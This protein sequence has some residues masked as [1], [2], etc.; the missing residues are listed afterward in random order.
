[1]DP[2]DL[3]SDTVTRPS[4]GMR[5]AMAS[6]EVGDDVFGD[7]PTVNRLQETVAQLLG[8]ERAL[9]VASG[10]MGN[11]VAVR[12]L[13]EPGQEILMHR[14]SHV[15]LY[16][17]G[18]YAA[19]SGC[20]V[21]LLDGER[22][23]ID[24][25]A[26][27]AAI[28]PAD[29]HHPRSSL[30][31][32]ENTHNRGGGTVWPVARMAEI[33]ALADTRG[34][35][36]HLDGARLMNAC[37]ASG[38]PATAYTRHADTV[39]ICFSKGLGA[40]VGSVL[41]A[42]AELITRAHR[43]RKQLGGGMRQAGILAAAAL[44]ALEHNVARLAEDHAH[45]R[46]LADALAGMPGVTIDPGAT[47]TNIVYFDVD[48]QVRTA[49]ALCDVLKADGVWMLA[50]GPQRVRAVTHLDVSRAGIERTIDALCRALRARARGSDPR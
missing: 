18:G 5:E 49:A 46:Q 15:Y 6:A 39:T 2:I 14:D 38:E 43:F 40:P 1:M 37:V 12:S 9:F 25:A 7:D 20:S 10:T 13:T 4:A 32:L 21:R 19:I 41:A 16:E 47:E 23:I 8:K 11:A 31:V 26:V 35:R 3:R 45:A 24:A 50:I 17:G 44:Y 42:S 27:G 33:R 48:P 29:D 28:R 30:I 34:L 22:G 36:V